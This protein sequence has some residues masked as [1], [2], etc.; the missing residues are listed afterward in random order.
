MFAAL[1]FAARAESWFAGEAAR[2]RAAKEKAGCG[3]GCWRVEVV[4][5]VDGNSDVEQDEVVAA[6]E[7]IFSSWIWVGVP[8]PDQAVLLGL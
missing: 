8:V 3:V 2:A 4:V 6:G 1:L 7:K 5:V